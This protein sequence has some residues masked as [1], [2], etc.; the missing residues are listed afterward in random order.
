[1]CVAPKSAQDPD[2]GCVTPAIAPDLGSASVPDL[3]LLI[4]FKLHNNLVS[5]SA[6]GPTRAFSSRQFFSTRHILHVFYSSQISF[7][8]YLY[9]PHMYSTQDK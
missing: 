4:Q 6:L 9:C 8:N 2:S 3:V 7:A 1:M 5:D